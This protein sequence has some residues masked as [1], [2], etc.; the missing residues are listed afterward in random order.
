MFL[1]LVLVSS[2]VLGTITVEALTGPSPTELV[3]L[4]TVYD[5]T[6]NNLTGE[7]TE[8][9]Y[10]AHYTE[11]GKTNNIYAMVFNVSGRATA[12]PNSD[13]SVI[14]YLNKADGADAACVYFYPDNTKRPKTGVTRTPATSGV[15]IISGKY[16]ATKA[17]ANG[18]IDYAKN[19]NTVG[20]N[21]YRNNTTDGHPYVE[22]NNLKVNV[23]YEYVYKV[24][25]DASPQT[26]TVTYR[27]VNSAADEYVINETIEHN[28]GIYNYIRLDKD[29]NTVDSSHY[30]AFKDVKYV[31]YE[32]SCQKADIITVGSDGI[33]DGGKPV[34]P[35]GQ[36]LIQF[37]LDKEIK[38][39][40][41]NHIRVESATS[42]NSAADIDV[43]SDGIK[44]IVT[45]ELENNLDPWTNYKLVIDKGAYAG[46]KQ[47]VSDISYLDLADLTAEFKTLSAPLDARAEIDSSGKAVFDL[48]STSA[49]TDMT[50]I[51]TN[52]T[53]DGIMKE[54]VSAGYTVNNSTIEDAEIVFNGSFEDGDIAKLFIIKSWS[55]PVQLFDKFWA[56][57]YDGT[58]PALETPQP[59]EKAQANTI[60]FDTYDFDTTFDHANKKVGVNLNTGKNAAVKGVL[61]IYDNTQALSGSNVIYADHITTASNGTW[62][63]EIKVDSSIT[64][65][66]ASYK[67]AFYS[68]EL[69]GAIT[70]VFD[71][72]STVNDDLLEHKR[73]KIFEYA[74]DSITFAGLKQ[75]ITGTDEDGHVVT[76]VWSIFKNDISSTALSKYEGL[77]NKNAVYN[78]LFLKLGNIATYRALCAEFAGIVNGQPVPGTPV[79][80]NNTTTPARPNV[81]VTITPGGSA[82]GTVGGSTGGAAVGGATPAFTDMSGH[83]AQKYAEALVKKGIVNGYADGSFQGD[84]PIT[85]A[86]LTK[87]IVEALEVPENDGKSFFD[88][89]ADSW[90][91]HY[92]SRASAAGVVNGFEDG[93]FGPDRYVSRQDA[94]LMIYRAMCLT[95]E[96]PVGY[97][98]FADEKDIQ[99]YASD[100]IRCL[101]DLGIV[102]G[103]GD[104]KFLPLNNITRGE[105]AAVICRSL[106]YMQSHL[107]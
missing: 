79:V 81:S 88:V 16:M 63:K 89:N 74:K 13:G 95:K 104:S 80:D 69:A 3:K 91:A 18:D 12:N 77:S 6:G 94:V 40:S 52:K 53:A 71:V 31:Y 56:E 83:W 4:E 86:E 64:N 85:R 68:P 25:L 21:G 14:H 28:T 60:S 78:D 50:V 92:V 61:Y 46:Y 54:I 37:E 42:I 100:A 39:L 96:L 84:N 8:G 2:M 76:D 23:W 75:V 93:S 33:T 20:L 5:T 44:W 10:Y 38:G 1:S 72:Y 34:V 66:T 103:S 49:S 105:M 70:N 27:S 48:A 36:N 67:V 45:A 41:K 73:N 51:F 35:H 101:A 55:D 26:F 59:T 24:D 102:N 98:F 19:N 99:D 22:I 65:T 107:Q 47:K 15:H 97:K 9:G 62:A 82:G 30:H 43:T 57:N 7:Y 11:D 106:D 32:D 17:K 29:F 87:I 58:N 90:Y